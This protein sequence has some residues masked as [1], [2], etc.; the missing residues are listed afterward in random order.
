MTSRQS[1]TAAKAVLSG[2]RTVALTL[3]LALI[4]TA[5][6][7]MSCDDVMNMVSVNVPDDIVIATMRGSGGS[8]AAADVQCLQQR[9]APPAVVAAA[10]QMSAPAQARMQPQP[11]NGASRAT[12]LACNSYR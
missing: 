10:Q 7:A 9:G 1:I 2:V 5:A 3:S 8:I 11:M 6:S 4:P 12:L